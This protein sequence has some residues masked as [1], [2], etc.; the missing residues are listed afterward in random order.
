MEGGKDIP[1]KPLHMSN[2]YTQTIMRYPTA[3][4]PC[5]ANCE[6]QIEMSTKNSTKIPIPVINRVRRLSRSKMLAPTILD[7]HPAR[8]WPRLKP[9]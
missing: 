8:L 6:L 3:F 7:S 1:V 9:N 5:N 2:M 4:E